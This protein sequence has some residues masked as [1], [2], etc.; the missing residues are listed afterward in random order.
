MIN[1]LKFEGS[2]CQGEIDIQVFKCQIR[3]TNKK[4]L[5]PEEEKEK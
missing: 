3:K 4:Y 2:G 5:N 1:F